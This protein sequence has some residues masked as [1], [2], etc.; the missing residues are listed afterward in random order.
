MKGGAI[1]SGLSM[2]WGVVGFGCCIASVILIVGLTGRS[3]RVRLRVEPEQ[4]NLGVMRQGE[5]GE[6]RLKLIN[7][8]YEPL[9]I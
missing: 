7:A 1:W 4:Y 2:V 3:E 5:V 8:G 6:A 9:E